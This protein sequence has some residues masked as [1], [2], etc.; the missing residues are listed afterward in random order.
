MNTSAKD[1]LLFHE[2]ITIYSRFSGYSGD[3]YETIGYL[4]VNSQ[5]VSGEAVES[6]LFMR[7]LVAFACWR[8][9]A[10]KS[11]NMDD[12]TDGRLGK[13]R[14]VALMVRC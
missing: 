3:G 8:S 4:A 11:I 7:E 9:L 2:R 5:T 10:R 6:V 12:P 14:V 1:I 13:K